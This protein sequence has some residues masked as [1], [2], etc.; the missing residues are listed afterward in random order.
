MN[1]SGMSKGMLHRIQLIDEFV[2]IVAPDVER[3]W[4]DGESGPGLAEVKCRLRYNECEVLVAVTEDSIRM[5]GIGVIVRAMQIHAT[6]VRIILANRDA[7]SPTCAAH[8]LHSISPA[9][10]E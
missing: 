3:Q 4:D 8:T 1:Y 6:P 7:R 2:Q 9:A 10:D 5:A